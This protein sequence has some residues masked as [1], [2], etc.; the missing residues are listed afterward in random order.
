MAEQVREDHV[1]SAIRWIACEMYAIGMIG[2]WC[3]GMIECE[4]D[5]KGE[6]WLPKVSPKL[7]D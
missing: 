4:R 6:L 5:Q 2:I 3:L 7:Y 1:S